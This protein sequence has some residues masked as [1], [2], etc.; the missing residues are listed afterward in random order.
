MTAGRQFP[1]VTAAGASSVP[2]PT[3]AAIP[4]SNPAASPCCCC[5]ARREHVPDEA[6]WRGGDYRKSHE[7]AP[8][9]PSISLSG[10][11]ECWVPEAVSSAIGG[12]LFRGSG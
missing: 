6:R 7:R 9:A 12:L 5:R 2:G 4:A 1:T 8:C 11:S 3:A 10:S